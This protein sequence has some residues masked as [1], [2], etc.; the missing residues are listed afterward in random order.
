LLACSKWRF[1][2]RNRP[3]L[4][5]EFTDS[6]GHSTQAL[7]DARGNLIQLTD[8]NGNA[9]KFEY[10]RNDRVVREILPLGQATDYG[11]DPAGNLIHG[12]MADGS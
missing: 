12:R 11:Y 6:L 4:L 5:T 8:A 3:T 2:A 7:Y 9:H 1:A 10:D